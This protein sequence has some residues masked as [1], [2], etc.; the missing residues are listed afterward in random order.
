MTTKNEFRPMLFK[1]DIGQMLQPG[2]PIVCVTTG[3]SHNVNV[4]KGVYRGLYVRADRPELITSVA[5][6]YEAETYDWKFR[7]MVKSKV[8]RSLPAKRV[9]KIAEA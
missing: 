3:Y 7:K 2:D 5:V 9:Y 4:R 6:E 1:N 8:K